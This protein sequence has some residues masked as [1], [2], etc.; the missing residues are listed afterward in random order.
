[1][2]ERQLV[3]ACAVCGRLLERYQGRWVHGAEVFG[4]P[5]HVAVPVSPDQVHVQPVCDFCHVDVSLKEVWT[6]EARDFQIL[7]DPGGPNPLPGYGSEGDWAACG[8]CAELV[9]HRDWPAVIER[10]CQ[11]NP[12][13]DDALNRTLL[14]MMFSALNDNIIRVRTIQGP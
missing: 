13:R 3:P 11:V 4:N 5:D 12:E 7:V 6:V 10:Y 2:S 1:M 9:R 14:T 8:T